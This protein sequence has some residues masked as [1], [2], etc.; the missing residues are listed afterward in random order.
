[1]V[2]RQKEN[3]IF[4]VKNSLAVEIFRLITIREYKDL[5]IIGAII[6]YKKGTK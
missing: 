3:D 1:M 2:V 5:A 4:N 6:C